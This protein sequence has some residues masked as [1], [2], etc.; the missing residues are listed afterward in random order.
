VEATTQ[1]LLA[2]GYDRF[3]T[4]RAADRAGVSIGSLYQYFPNKAAL[5]AAVIDRCCEGFISDVDRALAGRSRI[6]LTEC[7]RVIVEVMLI[8]HSL[9]PD[10]HK[11]I[12]D[13]APR[14]GVAD[15]TERASRKMAEAIE[16]ILRMHSGEIAV[17]LDVVQ[18]GSRIFRSACGATRSTRLSAAVSAAKA[19]CPAVATAPAASAC[20][21]RSRRPDAGLNIV[22]S[23]AGRLHDACHRFRNGAI[24]PA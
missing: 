9:T 18:N 24:S 7:I 1:L 10:L 4:A 22:V 23:W 5:V 2:Q 19:P 3:T 12:I 6:T 17:V 11:I 15:K 13:L 8:S 14:I 21:S 20:L 16:A